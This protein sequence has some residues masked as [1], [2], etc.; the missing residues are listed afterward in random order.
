MNSIARYLVSASV[1]T[2]LAATPALA[3]K[4]KD[5]TY[6]NGRDA[7]E[8]ERTIYD[9][10]FRNVSSHRSS[11]GYV[12]SYWWQ[13]KGDNC[14]VVESY[15]R[16]A[17]VMTIDDAPNKDCGHSGGISGGE[18][19]AIGVGAVLLG[20][21]IAGGKSHHREGRDY[22]ETQTAEF[23]RGY[24]DGLHHARYHNYN[25]ADA[26]AHGYEKGTEE[27]E[28]NLRDHHRRG[29]YSQVAQFADLQGTRAAGGMSE[30][31]R[32]G[33]RQVDNFTS[34]NARYSIQW[35]PESRQCLQVI[36]NNGRLEDIRD[37]Q[38]HPNCR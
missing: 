13:E 7:A 19:A 22:D 5:L 6:L 26:Y 17:Q 9:R 31:E 32:R 30:L 15:E 11:N 28:A 33:F 14:I 27:R 36:V 38:T 24:R 29:G 34:G 25:R 20:A 23:D 1:C 4:A 2:T 37:I 8:V 10:G 3:E 12:N 35:R 21:L 18:A 16:T